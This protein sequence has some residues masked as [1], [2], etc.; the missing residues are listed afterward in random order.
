[1]KKKKRLSSFAKGIVASVFA[2]AVYIGLKQN[3]R[4][5]I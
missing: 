3:G 5:E 2:L 4:S 1:M